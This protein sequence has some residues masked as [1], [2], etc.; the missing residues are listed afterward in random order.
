MTTGTQGIILLNDKQ[1]ASWLEVYSRR[2]RKMLSFPK[3]PS[4]KRCVKQFY[5]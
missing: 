1:L 2:D 4:I 5:H 3:L